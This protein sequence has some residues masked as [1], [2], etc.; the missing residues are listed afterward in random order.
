MNVDV[1]F[2]RLGFGFADCPNF[3]WGLIAESLL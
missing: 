3:S 2:D 1:S